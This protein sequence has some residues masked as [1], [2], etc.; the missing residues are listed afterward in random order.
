M[1]HLV[2]ED[3]I[4][5]LCSI[6][7]LGSLVLVYTNVDFHLPPEEILEWTRKELQTNSKNILQFQES[8]FKDKET[9]EFLINQ[10]NNLILHLKRLKSFLEEGIDKQYKLILES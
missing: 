5:K 10:S 9:K 1:P 8:Y 6:F 7:D 2:F 4:G 3:R